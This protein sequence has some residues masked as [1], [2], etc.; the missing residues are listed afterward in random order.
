MLAAGSVRNE[1]TVGVDDQAE[2]V[3]KRAILE[4]ADIHRRAGS[5]RVAD[6]ERGETVRERVEVAHREIEGIVGKPAGEVVAECILSGGANLVGDR[7][8]RAAQRERARAANRTAAGPEIDVVGDDRNIASARTGADDARAMRE[9][10]VA[11]VEP[12]IDEAIGRVEAVGVIVVAGD[13]KAVGFLDDDVRVGTGAGVH[14]RQD[15]DGGIERAGDADS[16]EGV[17]RGRRDELRIPDIDQT[18][19]F[20]RHAD[21]T[22]VVAIGRGAAEDGLRRGVGQLEHVERVAHVDDL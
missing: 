16:V 14:D 13:L 9:K 3:G 4:V 5:V 11:S 7:I 22:P 15:V 20:D 10:R 8:A 1:C 18:A 12:E 19:G 17:T 21:R 2:V 6:A